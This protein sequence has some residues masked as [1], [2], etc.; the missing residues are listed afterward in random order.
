MVSSSPRIAWL[1]AEGVTPIRLAARVKLRS[2]ATV[3]NAAKMLRSSRAILELYSQLL[4][5]F[6]VLSN[7]RFSL[8][9]SS[10]ED[11]MRNLSFEDKV[12]LVTGAGSG[13]GL[14]TAQMFAAEGAAVAL[15]DI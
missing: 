14:T 3:R 10:G 15:V 1:I 8:T 9:L 7:A 5:H 13:M 2:S 11:S 6:P 4:V 12:A